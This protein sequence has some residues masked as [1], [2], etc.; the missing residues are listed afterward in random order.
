[1]FYEVFNRKNVDLG[2]FIRKNVGFI[3][4]NGIL[5]GIWGF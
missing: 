4:E 3:R 1:V 2:D 5:I